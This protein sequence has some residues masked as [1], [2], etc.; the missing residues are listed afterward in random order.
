MSKVVINVVGGVVQEVSVDSDTIE[1]IL[2]DF[3]HEDSEELS[4]KYVEQVL[5]NPE[6]KPVNI[7][8]L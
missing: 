5:D 3:D 8:S 7:K 4:A 1:V 2:V 6:F